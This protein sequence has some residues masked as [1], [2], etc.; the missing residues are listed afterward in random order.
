MNPART[1]GRQGKGALDR[2][3]EATAAPALHFSCQSILAHLGEIRWLNLLRTAMVDVTAM[4]TTHWYGHY[5]R[6]TVALQDAL[7]CLTPESTTRA[8]HAPEIAFARAALNA[9]VGDALSAWNAAHPDALLR[10]PPELTVEI[11][12]WLEFRDR[13]TVSHVSRRWREITLSDPFLWNSASF[14]GR[15]PP[16]DWTL[17]RRRRGPPMGPLR[18]K[19]RVFRELLARSSPV[20]FSLTWEDEMLPERIF[21]IVLQN[22]HRMQA[23]TV[24]LSRRGF[25]RLCA[26]P[27]PELRSLVGTR[28]SGLCLF[29]ASW[30]APVLQTLELLSV[31]FPAAGAIA[32]LDAVRELVVFAA[33]GLDRRGFRF[34]A[35][36][37]ALAS[38]EIICF[39]PEMTPSLSHA[40]VALAN[41]KL[42]ARERVDWT[43]VLAAFSRCSPKTLHMSPV[44]DAAPVLALFV[45]LV[46][47]TWTMDIRPRAQPHAGFCTNLISDESSIVFAFDG[48]EEPSFVCDALS[49][50][51]R[52]SSLTA[53]VPILAE[54]DGLPVEQW[55]RRLPALRTLGLICAGGTTWDESALTAI[56]APRLERVSIHLP[57][58]GPSWATQRFPEVLRSRFVYDRP[59]LAEIKVEAKNENGLQ[60][61]WLA[62]LRAMAE[63]VIVDLGHVT[64]VYTHE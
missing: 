53:P 22:L 7:G 63:R 62:E 21:D 52:V 35:V 28:Y 1:C 17:R 6:L 34:S 27:A 49:Y 8:E 46:S 50:L 18:K 42:I 24:G 3:F 61:N 48:S 29:P 56:R 60:E 26:L 2:N 25:Q 16:I 13:I 23:L 33:S 39:T 12:H 58:G 10:L 55:D 20:P 14:S 19:A 40:P 64:R 57:D 11:F 47:G 32:R 43:P 45:S 36:F 38:L 9:A 31:R 41:L 5:K 15:E 54:L 44:H 30:D 4:S 59:L 37:P 51:D